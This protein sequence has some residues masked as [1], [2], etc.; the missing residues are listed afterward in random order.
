[1]PTAL[2]ESQLNPTIC[3]RM[4][5]AYLIESIPRANN[6]AL[7]QATGWPRRTIQDIIA[8]GLPGHG[9]FVEFMQE[10]VRH[11][12][13]YYLLRDWGSFDRNWVKT[14]LTIICQVLAVKL[15]LSGAVS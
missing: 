6:P 5:I 7:E 10:G 11:N 1:M 14:H 12:D 8:K 4:L 13:G 2:V 3:R 9:T 15:D